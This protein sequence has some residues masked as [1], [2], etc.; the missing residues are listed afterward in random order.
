MIRPTCYNG[1]W[2]CETV[3]CQGLSEKGLI[4][5]HLAEEAYKEYSAQGHSSQSFERLHQRGGFAVDELA[6][7]LYE[8][9]KRL[10]KL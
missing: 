1:K 5:K 4:P 9:I 8:R 3:P 2:D 10:E 7:L 6:Q